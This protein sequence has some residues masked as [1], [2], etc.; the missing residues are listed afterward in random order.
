MH[1]AENATRQWLAEFVIRLNLC[2]FARGPFRAEKIQYTVEAATDREALL[3]GYLTALQA[4]I[5]QPRQQVETTLII[6]PNALEAFDDYLDFVDT[7]EYLLEEAG[8]SGTIQLASFHPTYVFADAE[9]DDPANATN[10]S[11]YP[12]LH[13]LREESVEEVRLHYA[14]VEDI[15]Q[16]NI[17]LLRRL[18][19]GPGRELSDDI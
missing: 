5:A 16:R 11:P 14:G 18:A 15:P 9:V 12:M 7:A 1:P 10:R 8:L 2:P 13:L 3:R 6:Y 4:L 19:A 17:E